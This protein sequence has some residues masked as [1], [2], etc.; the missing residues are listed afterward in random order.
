MEENEM[1]SVSNQTINVNENANQNENNINENQNKTDAKMPEKQHKKSKVVR[2]VLDENSNEMVEKEFEKKAEK[3][4]SERT[5]KGGQARFKNRNENKSSNDANK[6]DTEAKLSENGNEKVNAN[7]NKNKK[8]NQISKK[9]GNNKKG[10]KKGD[11]INGN[12]S[13]ERAINDKSNAVENKKSKMQQLEARNKRILAENESAKIDLTTRAYK[14]KNLKVMFF[15]GV[16]NVGNNITALMY[17]DDILVIDC[18]VGFAEANMPGV[19]LVIPEM[20]FLKANK[21]KIRGI[22]ITHA[23]EDHIGSM[24]YFLDEVKAPVYA[25]KLS[26][27]LI[28][29]KL[30]EFPK[31]KM[32]GVAVNPRQTVKIGCF[33]VEFIHVNHSIAGAYALAITTPVGVV[34]H[35]GDFKID[36]TPTAGETTDLARM[37]ELGNKGV[38][39]MLCESTNIERPGCSLSENVVGETIASIFEEARENRIIITAFA[40]N[41]HRVQQIMNLAKNYGRKV[42]FAGRSM[43]NN[44]EVAMKI[45]EIKFDHNQI[46][47]MAKVPKMADK[48]VLILATGSQGQEHTA[49]DRMANGEFQGIEIGKNDTVIFSSSPVPGNEKSVTNIINELMRK[50]ANVIYDD[51]SDVH[52][53]GH[54]CQ[55]EFAVVHKLI[56]PKFFV[57]VH[58]EVKHLMYHEKFAIKMGVNPKNIIVPEIGTVVEVNKNSMRKGKDVYAGIRIVDGKTVGD[59]ES[60]VLKDRLQLASDGIAIVLLHIDEATGNLNRLPDIFTRG[61]IYNDDSSELI[62]EAKRI[63]YEALENVDVKSMEKNVLRNTVKKTL[64]NFFVRKVNRKPMIITII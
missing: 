16:G 1:K 37:G 13:E 4:K 36:F 19:D 3:Q 64:T 50:G 9:G 21:D 49:L 42:A 56:K 8:S 30:R 32:K 60:A 53:S 6:N 2:Y 25:S 18:G 58:G 46:V 27:A 62:I 10:G 63:V 47:E 5:A 51:L 23:H 40:S 57:P 11:A 15:G 45:G 43:I 28:E 48:E 20:S 29:N 14:N 24:P 38:L 35:S 39:L 55:T 59:V 22:C 33:T 26:L 31:C 7:L 34:F 12:A 61:F 17:G 44:M 54:A 52:A 41:V